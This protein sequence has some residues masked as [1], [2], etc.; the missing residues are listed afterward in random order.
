[1]N[2]D[3]DLKTPDDSI[4][5]YINSHTHT[6]YHVDQALQSKHES[7]VDRGANAGLAGSDERILSKTPRQSS[8]KSVNNHVM[9]DL[10]TVQCAA[11]ANTNHGIVN[12]IMNEYDTLD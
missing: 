1:M 7:F 9:Q 10:D 4:L 8:L 11:L 6:T 12:L 5:D 2:T 3:H